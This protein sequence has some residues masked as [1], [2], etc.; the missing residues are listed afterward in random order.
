M[1]DC[2]LSRVDR[3]DFVVVGRLFTDCANGHSLCSAVSRFVLC[4][5]AHCSEFSAPL[6]LFRSVVDLHIGHHGFDVLFQSGCHSFGG[7]TNIG[8]YW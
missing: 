2:D 1:R 5:G 8:R 3:F 4:L 7:A 6:V